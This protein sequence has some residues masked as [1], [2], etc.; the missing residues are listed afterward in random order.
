[1]LLGINLPHCKTC[2]GSY[3]KPQKKKR[4]ENGIENFDAQHYGGTDT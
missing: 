1:V 4:V 2:H 3:D